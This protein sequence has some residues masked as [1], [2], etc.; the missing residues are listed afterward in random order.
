[1]L[2]VFFIYAIKWKSNRFFHSGYCILNIKHQKHASAW[3]YWNAPHAFAFLFSMVTNCFTFQFNQWNLSSSLPMWMFSIYLWSLLY[4]ISL[5]NHNGVVFLFFRALKRWS[6]KTLHGR[7]LHPGKLWSQHSEVLFLWPGWAL[8]QISHAIK[9]FWIRFPC[10]HRVKSLRRM[11]LR[12]LWS[13][14]KNPE[15]QM[16]H[17]LPCKENQEFEF[18][19]L[20]YFLPME[21][22]FTKSVSTKVP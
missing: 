20:F 22:T 9:I 15:N 11:L 8:S 7:R 10:S 21:K 19:L 5:K 18:G 12:F 2:H 16:A 3:V 4:R 14:I 1:M 13:L 6:V 17:F